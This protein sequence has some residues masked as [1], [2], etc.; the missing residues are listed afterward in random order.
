MTLETPIAAV[1][2][3][4]AD[5]AAVNGSQSRS[6]AFQA[7]LKGQSPSAVCHDPAPLTSSHLQ[8]FLEMPKHRLYAYRDR[9][10]LSRSAGT[11]TAMRAESARPLREHLP[12]VFTYGGA[13]A[14]GPFRRAVGRC[15]RIRS[16]SSV[17]L[18]PR[19]TGNALSYD[20][21]GAPWPDRPHCHGLRV[22]LRVQDVVR[23][24][25]H[26]RGQR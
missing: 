16:E 23:R 4:A 6:C 24:T 1:R 13:R 10:S 14:P 20:R 7:L 18:L 9:G 25:G 22:A 26:E 17:N 19:P 3:S 21:A 5:C 11:C 12:A 8:D 2:A 15:T